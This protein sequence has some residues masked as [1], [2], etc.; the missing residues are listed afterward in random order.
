VGALRGRLERPDQELSWLCDYWLI[1]SREWRSVSLSSP[2][3]A[4]G[5]LGLT[6]GGG[7][8][9]EVAVL[10]GDGSLGVR[11]DGGDVEALLASDVQEVGVGGLNES[12]KFV[13]MLLLDRIGIQKVHFHCARG[14]D[15]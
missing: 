1:L 2:G 7:A 4:N 8:K 10:A 6:S 5:E 11:E 3:R 13:Q 15:E 14:V 9:D 12:L